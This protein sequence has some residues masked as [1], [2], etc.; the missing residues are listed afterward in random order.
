[1]E[2]CRTITLTKERKIVHGVYPLHDIMR[3]PAQLIAGPAKLSFD[4][5][6]LAALCEGADSLAADFQWSDAIRVSWSILITDQ[7]DQKPLFSKTSGARALWLTGEIIHGLFEVFHG[8]NH[9]L[10]SVVPDMD[11]HHLMLTFEIDQGFSAYAS[12]GSA[13]CFV[14]L[15]DGLLFV[16]GLQLSSS[17]I[18]LV[19]EIN[20]DRPDFVN[21]YR[22]IF[23]ESHGY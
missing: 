22:F 15:I 2:L 7:L 20:L 1:M 17:N 14:S 21:I 4:S 23:T 11:T 16:R 9:R 8:Y 5:F 6:H 13:L 19:D 3:A 10:L 12:I 18:C